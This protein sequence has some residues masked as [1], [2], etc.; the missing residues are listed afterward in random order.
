MLAV[1]MGIK[2]SPV[3]PEVSRQTQPAAEQPKP[4]K[5]MSASERIAS[6]IGGSIG[7]LIEWYDWLVYS[8]FSLYF[9]KSF[10]PNGS[11]TAQ[12]L[13][14]AGIFAVGYLMRPVGSVLMGVYADR[15]GRRAALALSVALMCGGSAIIAITP[16][17]KSIGLLAPAILVAARLLQGI[18]VGGEYGASA[19]YLA[20]I[21]T[22][23]WRGFYSSFQ[24]VTLQGGQLTAV[25][26][27]LLLQQVL[28][29]PAQLDEWG[30]R[31]PFAL[32]AAMSIGGYFLV[33]RIAESHA[34]TVHRK[35]RPSGNILRELMRHKTS[36]FRVA[37][38]TVGGTVAIYTYTIYM[39]KFLVNSG[40][41][42]KSASS[43]VSA[44]SLFIFILIQPLVG[45][46]SDIVGR[47]PVL[48]AFGI[49]GS[50]LTVPLMTAISHA[51]SIGEVIGLLFVGLVMVSGYTAVNAAAKAELFPTGVRALGV[52]LP[53][54]LIVA[55]FGGSTEYA[56]LWFKNAG[57]EPW[58]YWYVTACILI[59]LITYCFIPETRKRDLESE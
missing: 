39:Q 23:Q 43:L 53:Y 57:H 55:V 20:E 8:A 15:K 30:W 12:L 22:P 1:L 26:V 25:L 34:F 45:A 3:S 50:L 7:N 46:L 11:Q 33:Q 2:T 21:A 42:S 10:F 36:V 17:Y 56:G 58:F 48:I 31:I 24:Y 18:S 37:G 27:L 13:N 5:D 44:L 59:S 19:T 38:M 49:L 4:A 47:K 35:E 41:L 14:T 29:T 28:L 40:G 6:I 32:G 54:A 51:K 9:A 52:G 16:G